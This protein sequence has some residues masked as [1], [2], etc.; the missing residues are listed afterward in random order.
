MRSEKVDGGDDWN[1]AEVHV[2]SA[3]HTRLVDAL[4]A[5]DWNCADVQ[6]VSVVHARFVDVVGAV[7]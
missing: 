5:L 1:C 2:V 4:G 3:V 7:L 6:V